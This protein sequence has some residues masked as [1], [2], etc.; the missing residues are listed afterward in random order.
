MTELIYKDLF[1]YEY[2]IFESN[3]SMMTSTYN[4][5]LN[6]FIIDLDGK[7]YAFKTYKSFVT[8]KQSFIF[9]FDLNQF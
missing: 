7:K 2:E 9:K 3:E 8:K 5:R 1:T 4:E 6:M